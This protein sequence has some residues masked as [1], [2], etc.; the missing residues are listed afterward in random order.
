MTI[1]HEYEIA[2]DLTEYDCGPGRT[3]CRAWTLE[4]MESVGPV[5]VSHAVPKE[6]MRRRDPEAFLATVTYCCVAPPETPGRYTMR[7]RADGKVVAEIPYEVR[8]AQ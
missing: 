8:A 6:P 7:L 3:P 4:A 5:T 2:F 1:G